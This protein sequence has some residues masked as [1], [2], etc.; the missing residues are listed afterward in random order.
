MLR[1][2]VNLIIVEHRLLIQNGII[3]S[4]YRLSTPRRIR[5]IPRF[6]KETGD[7]L[8]YYCFFG[9]LIKDH[10]IITICPAAPKT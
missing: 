9:F 6:L 7:F 10:K 4:L 1:R 8:Y 3:E 2:K 5:K